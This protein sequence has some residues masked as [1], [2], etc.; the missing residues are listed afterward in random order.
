MF[1]VRWLSVLLLISGYVHAQQS[2]PLPQIINGP[3]P[4]S[5]T[6]PA[7]PPA[8]TEAPQAPAKAGP[9]ETL[10]S[11]DPMLVELV[12]LGGDWKVMAG[13]R[14]LKNFGRRQDEA[15]QAQR[16]IR[17]LHL[18]QYG[19]I[20][21]PAPVVEY[22]LSN[23][24][25]PQGLVH[26]LRSLPI[27]LASLQVQS[28][29]GQTCLRD[30]QR[31]LF[32]FGRRQ[33]LAE[34][35]LAVLKKYQFNKLAIVGQATPS[36][37]VFLSTPADLR[38]LPRHDTHPTLHSI[39]APAEG[40]PPNGPSPVQDLYVTPAVA[41]LRVDGRHV[42]GKPTTLVQTSHLH[43][44]ATTVPGFEEI[45]TR[46]PF[47]WRLVQLVPAA[48][49][50]RL[51]AGSYVLANFGG[52]ERSARQA[53]QAV[54]FYRFTEHHLVGY[55]QTQFSY[56]LVGGQAPYG[57]PFGVQG[58]SFLADQLRVQQDNGRFVLTSGDRPLVVLGQREDEARQLL[59]IIRR[60]KFDRLCQ[61]GQ[62]P[63]HCLTFFTRS[64]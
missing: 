31:I 35:A 52:D 23:G 20:G 47:D 29:G 56:F 28:A 7:P 30:A 64:R 9:S 48:D 22:W 45:I 25:A 33:D 40:R 4:G 46:V 53:L 37:L 6:P 34:Q 59:Q 5:R 1:R 24:A 2:A 58:E 60:H 62:Q 51:Q 38:Q 61:I 44:A 50:W 36:M 54:Q 55:P 39:R 17:D 26:G 42:V 16:L 19:T 57:V 32:N 49:G 18:N 3:P 11:F 63:G 15:R 10:I 21:D 8:Q 14:E 27:D 13:E 12:W 41:P 43:T